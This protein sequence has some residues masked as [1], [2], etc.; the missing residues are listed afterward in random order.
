MVEDDDEPLL[1]QGRGRRA[2]AGVVLTIL[3]C[4]IFSLILAP[5]FFF[6][7]DADHGFTALQE[8]AV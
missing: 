7:S 4:V 3:F 2:V 8:Y 1:D 6:H 5:P